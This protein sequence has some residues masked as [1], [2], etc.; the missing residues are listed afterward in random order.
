M[1]IEVKET[2]YM[3][4]L[5]QHVENK[6]WQIVLHDGVRILFPTM[7]DAQRACRQFRD[8]ANENRGKV[9]IQQ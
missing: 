4:F 7:Q 9:I 5:L 8:I 2:T 3:G 6:G 1:I